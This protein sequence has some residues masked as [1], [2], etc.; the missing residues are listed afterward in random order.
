MNSASFFA[1]IKPLFSN[2]FTQ[3][4]VDGINHILS[5]ITE[6]GITDLRY[7]A[8]MLA[9]VFHETAKTMQ[10]IR[11][12]GRGKGYD[13]GKKL[14]MSRK[15]YV[16]PDQIFYGR[17][18]V[19]LTWYENYDSMGKLLKIDLLNNPDLALNGD[20]SAQIMIKGMM[21]GFFTGKALS[22]YFNDKITD[23]INARRIINGTDK[24]SL[25]ADYAK[26]FYNGLL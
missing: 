14:K 20:V 9:T 15:P 25:I 7:V 2:K 19:Q 16:T 13:Y 5:A 23:W 10:P 11:E 4:Q 18:L 24:S 12:Y 21:K 3:N 17:G 22:H 8:Y 26:V 1:T 6:A